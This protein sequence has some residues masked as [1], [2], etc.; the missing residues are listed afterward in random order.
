MEIFHTDKDNDCFQS[1]DQKSGQILSSWLERS[2][3]DRKKILEEIHYANRNL[4]AFGHKSFQQWTTY[5]ASSHRISGHSAEILGAR[6][7]AIVNWFVKEHFHRS[8][9]VVRLEELEQLRCIYPDISTKSKLQLARIINCFDLKSNPRSLDDYFISDWRKSLERWPSFAFV[10]DQYWCIRATSHYEM[11]LVG[12]TEED[13]AN[14]GWWHRLISTRNGKS[15]FEKNSAMR[16]LRG[17]YADAYYRWQ[18]MRFIADTKKFRKNNNL[19]YNHL[20]DLLNQ[21]PRFEQIW[22]ECSEHNERLI[23]GQVSIPVPFYR[24]DGTLL[25][26]LE[27]SSLIP[28]T[29]NYRLILWTP[30]NAIAD[31]YLAEI[32]KW[33][34]EPGRFS[35]KAYFLRDYQHFFTE[36]QKLALG[37]V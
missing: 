11:A 26:M 23:S 33:A 9:T 28:D 22:Q 14:W 16:T 1:A 27:V 19:R 20:M 32:R 10:T 6:L 37:L 25:W 29:D 15:K 35:K 30:L 5:G 2:G 13:M 3:V 8:K 17:P 34:D 18:M 21:T 24:S 12:H 31:E 4:D 36:E 7:I